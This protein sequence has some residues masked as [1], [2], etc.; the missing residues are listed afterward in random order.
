M[1]VSNRAEPAGKTAGK[2]TGFRR[3]KMES[4][5]AARNSL[6]AC[7]ALLSQQHA[8][9]NADVGLNDEGLD[10]DFDT[11]GL[12]SDGSQHKTHVQWV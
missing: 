5:V 7:A 11:A 9:E 2:L 4:L 8:G 3:S 12:P 10:G 1:E 6:G